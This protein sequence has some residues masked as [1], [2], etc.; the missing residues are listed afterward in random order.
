MNTRFAAIL[1]SASALAGEQGSA[2]YDVLETWKCYP[3]GVFIRED[4]APLLEKRKAVEGGRIYGAVKFAG[5]FYESL[6]EIEGAD[7]RWDFGE[8]MEYSFV[9]T[10]EGS[11]AYYDFRNVEAGE[12]VPPKLIYSCRQS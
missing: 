11:A 1:I 4:Q 6:F 10:P 5:T 2:D 9:I 8:D 7:R 3:D 12:K